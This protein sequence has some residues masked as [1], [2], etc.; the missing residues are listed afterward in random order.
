MRTN[1]DWK[2]G[3]EACLL[4]VVR[5]PGSGHQEAWVLPLSLPAAL[6]GY[7]P[8]VPVF[9]PSRQTMLLIEATSQVSVCSYSH[10]AVCLGTQSCLTLVTPWTVA[11]QAPLSMGILQASVLEWVA[12]PS[13]KGS[14][15]PRDRSWIFHIAGRFFTI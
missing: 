11:R 9:L 2:D 15:Q 10:C 14:S 1:L 4:G 12:M 3:T 8:G 6:Q 13:S 7:L 5:S